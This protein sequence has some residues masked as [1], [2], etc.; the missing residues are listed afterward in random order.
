MQQTL[1]QFK[2]QVVLITGATGFTGQVLTR[3]LAK[4]GAIIRAVARASSNLEP[5]ADLD[6]EWHRGE[7]Y[8][9]AT[10]TKA[11]EGV[12]YIFH[13]AAAFRQ[14]KATD[15]DYR[16]VHVYS[17]QI[18]AKAV[19]GKPEF[20]CFVHVSTVGIHGHIEIEAADETYRAAPGDGY[21]R[22]KLEGEQWI[23]KYGAESGLPHTVVRP[24]PIYGPGDMRLLKF[25]KMSDKGFTLMLGPGKGKMQLV[26]VDD[27]T[28]VFLKAAT[29]PAAIGE[30]F[31][32]ISGGPTTIIEMGQIIADALDKKNRIIRLPL[33]PFFLASDINTKLTAW[34]GMP[35][36]MYRRRVGFYTKDRRFDATKMRTVLNYEP[37]YDNKKGLGET[38]HWYREQGLLGQ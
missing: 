5:L 18:L 29:T 12:N 23:L 4:A 27:L 22:T 19:T 21:Q 16:K 15:E 36:I 26:H 8:D 38:A 10:L 35:A 6:I 37:I 14:E 34:F 1:S 28:N 32:A 9:E 2:D 17:T 7:V 11:A 25:F 30:I 31:I 33:W 20:K 24:G 13:A 3:K